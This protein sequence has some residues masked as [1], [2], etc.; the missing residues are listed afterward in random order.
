M[1]AQDLFFLLGLKN[2]KR[3]FYLPIGK[4]APTKNLRRIPSSHSGIGL[5]GFV[6][7]VVKRCTLK[8]PRPTPQSMLTFSFYYRD[9][10]YHDLDTRDVKQLVSPTPKPQYAET[11]MCSRVDF[12]TVPSLN[13]HFGVHNIMNSNEYVSGLLTTKL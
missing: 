1:S 3:F 2:L 5:R 9:F 4:S 11:S 12:S 10:P 7:S 13:Q 8:S 6:R